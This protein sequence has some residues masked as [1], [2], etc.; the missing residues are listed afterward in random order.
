M[1]PPPPPESNDSPIAA[2]AAVQAWQQVVNDAAR[3]RARGCGIGAPPPN[4]GPRRGDNIRCNGDGNGNGDGATE[5]ID[6]ITL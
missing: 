4:G 6:G 5:I 3:M 2:A 1:L